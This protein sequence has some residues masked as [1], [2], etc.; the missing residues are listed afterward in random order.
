MLGESLNKYYRQTK[1]ALSIIRK[2]R[3]FISMRRLS[4]GFPAACEGGE[5]AAGARTR[6]D[7]FVQK[8]VKPLS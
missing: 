6:T 7:T 8:S 5:R 2:G 3:F 1:T 4:S